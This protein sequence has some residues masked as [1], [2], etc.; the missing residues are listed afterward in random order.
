[1]P[2][3]AT[4]GPPPGILDASHNISPR[5]H[6]QLVLELEVRKLLVELRERLPSRV[7]IGKALPLDQQAPLIA[8]LLSL[9]DALGRRKMPAVE[10]RGQLISCCKR[11]AVVGLEQPH[12]ED[13][14]KSCAL[15]KL[16]AIGD[17]TNAF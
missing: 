10:D 2:N 7:V 6:K 16:Q 9:Q 12:V 8:T 17:G 13:V 11:V 4:N 15:W 3:L 1:V 5:L 14:V